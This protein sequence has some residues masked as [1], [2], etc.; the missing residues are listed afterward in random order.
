MAQGSSRASTPASR[1]CCRGRKRGRDPAQPIEKKSF[2]EV[3]GVE[4]PAPA[5]RFSR[6]SGA[7]RAAFEAAKAAARRSPRGFG[8]AEIDWL[9]AQGLGCS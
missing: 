8:D 5:P 4:Q 3:S 1:R 7:A 2:L 6:T 9:A